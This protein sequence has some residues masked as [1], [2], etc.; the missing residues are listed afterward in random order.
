LN[1]SA[2]PSVHSSWVR[3]RTDDFANSNRLKSGTCAIFWKPARKRVGGSN[4]DLVIA[5][6]RHEAK[7]TASPPR[8]ANLLAIRVHQRPWRLD[9]EQ[10]ASRRDLPRQGKPPQLLDH[11]GLNLLRECRRGESQREFPERHDGHQHAR[12][13]V[14]VVLR[15]PGLADPVTAGPTA[16]AELDNSANCSLC[17][18]CRA[19]CSAV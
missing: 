11:H 12:P 9:V 10:R 19:T 7:N 8:L 15:A 14:L 13:P 1:W 5:P 16:N 3:C 17:S 2:S 18:R 4:R 6:G